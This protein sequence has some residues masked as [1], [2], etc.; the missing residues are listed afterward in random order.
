MDESR[1]LEATSRLISTFAHLNSFCPSH[2]FGN[3]HTNKSKNA[4]RNPLVVWRNYI[5]VDMFW[6][7]TLLR[8]YQQIIINA[9][10][11]LFFVG[12]C[13]LIIYRWNDSICFMTPIISHHVLVS[14]DRFSQVRYQKE[15]P[16]A[17]LAEGWGTNIGTQWMHV[18]DV[19]SA[20]LWSSAC[21][22]VGQIDQS[23]T[24]SSHVSDCISVISPNWLMV[25]TVFWWIG[26]EVGTL[27]ANFTS[28]HFSLHF[29]TVR[30]QIWC[31]K[32]MQNCVVDSHSGYFQP[33]ILGEMIQVD[34]YFS[35]GLKPSTRIAF[36]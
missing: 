4:D 20:E 14:N 13:S 36:G 23:G 2:R 29:C 15:R 35:D 3:Q 31:R 27:A 19:P 12:G 11:K 22:N 26:D 9:I 21:R 10:I 33:Y 32:T 5:N 18:N 16:L 1:P 7:I 17:H 24:H 25:P 6:A 34:Q 30:P 8:F 28:I